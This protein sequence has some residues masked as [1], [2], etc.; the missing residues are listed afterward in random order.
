M[1]VSFE[2]A[3]CTSRGCA[4]TRT[5]MATNANIFHASAPSSNISSVFVKFA[6]TFTEG[7]E[8]RG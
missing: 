6:P 5:R 2:S 7:D 1:I 4:P 8:S 3:P